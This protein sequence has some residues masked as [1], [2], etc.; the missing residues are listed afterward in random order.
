[1]GNGDTVGKPSGPP[2]VSTDGHNGVVT[3][4][5]DRHVLYRRMSTRIHDVSRVDVCPAPRWIVTEHHELDSFPTACEVGHS[6]A[7]VV[8]RGSGPAFSFMTWIQIISSSNVDQNSREFLVFPLVRNLLLQPATRRLQDVCSEG[9]VD[10][11]FLLDVLEIFVRREDRVYCY[12]T[13]WQVLEFPVVHCV[14]TSPYW[15][16]SSHRTL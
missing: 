5:R 9:E 6:S 12:V 11:K 4:R 15:Q 10:T 7:E 16:L 8:S 1:L 2:A 14:T 3:Q 13:C